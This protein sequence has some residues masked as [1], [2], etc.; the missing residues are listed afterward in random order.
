[1][2]H[3]KELRKE[4]DIPM[5]VSMGSMAASG[6]YYIAMA[7]GDQE[8][9][10]Y[11]EPLTTTGSI[12]VIIPHYN[13]SGL[14]KKYEVEDDSLATH[15][16]KTMLSISRRMTDDDKEVLGNYIGHAFDRFKDVIKEGRPQFRIDPAALD[17]LATGEI[18]TAKQA[19]ES[20]L[21]DEIG[22]IEDAIQRVLELTD[23]KEETTRVITYNQPVTLADAF[24]LGKTPGSEQ[25]AVLSSVLKLSN[26][27]AYY[28]TAPLANL[29][30]GERD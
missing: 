11:A 14:M 8:K 9:S 17:V 23:L 26:Q 1:L 12:G 29:L 18:F 5:V 3:L 27:Q 15:P 19:K 2:H 25:N 13:V 28:I 30:S 16:R 4:R 7:V 20:G 10:I 21:V 24:A 22:F 6:G